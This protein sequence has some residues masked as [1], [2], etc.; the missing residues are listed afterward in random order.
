M[1]DHEWSYWDFILSLKV[2]TFNIFN[3]TLL[4]VTLRMIKN[5]LIATTNFKII[6]F[7]QLIEFDYVELCK[8]S[9]NF[10]NHLEYHLRCS[11]NDLK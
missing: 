6:T 9:S 7:N 8:D 10:S 5:I 4:N 1:N 11:P 2:I 3:L